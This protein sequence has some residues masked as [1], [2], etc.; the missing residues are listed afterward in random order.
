M[1][2]N[3]CRLLSDFYQFIGELIKV[4]VT[5]VA[6]HDDTCQVPNGSG[7]RRLAIRLMVR[8]A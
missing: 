7:R 1:L 6:I 5:D 4:I 2:L 3:V 8:P